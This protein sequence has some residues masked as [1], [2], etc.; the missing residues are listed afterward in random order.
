VLK[1]IFAVAAL[2][3]TLVATTGSAGAVATGGAGLGAPTTKVVV[4]APRVP[5]LAPVLAPVPGMPQLAAGVA[6][7]RVSRRGASAAAI[8]WISQAS[9]PQR[10]RIDVVRRSDGLSIYDVVRKVVP[11]VPQT[12]VWNGRALG[13]PALD[14]PYEFRVSLG[15]GVAARSQGAPASP[16]VPAIPGG[17][18]SPD[19]VTAAPLGIAPPPGAASVGAFSF[20]G[21]I[22]PVRGAHSYGDEANGFGAGRNGHAHQGQDV[23]AKCGTPLVAAV[24]GV[25]RTRA[26]QSNAGNYIV[27]DDPIT[28]QSYVYAHLRVPAFFGHGAR[29]TAGE[30]IGVVGETGDATT[31][32]L[33]FEQWTAPGWYAGGEPIDP[34]ATLKRWDRTS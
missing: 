9:G 16:A 32:H 8:G 30:P 13:G 21:S 22:F 18:A 15:D 27:I 31:C 29:V 7:R 23:L 33:H 1:S 3:G 25:V 10:V 28:K 34:L 12:L 17:G 14:G 2:L 20:V 24:G 5:A 4:K 11:G 6:V 19:A 26:V